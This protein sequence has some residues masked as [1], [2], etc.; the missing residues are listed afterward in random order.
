MVNV[1]PVASFDLSE[2]VFSHRP[3][4]GTLYWLPIT[5]SYITGL[6]IRVAA[7]HGNRSCHYVMERRYLFQAS[8]DFHLLCSIRAFITV[9]PQ[10]L[11][12]HTERYVRPK[13]RL[14][15]TRRSTANHRPESELRAQGQWPFYIQL[16]IPRLC[17]L[18][19]R[20]QISFSR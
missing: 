9:S 12:I 18:N 14:L 13:R 3:S 17:G 4:Q 5:A 11:L 15:Q 19:V 7:A 1:C 6:V 10:P 8:C 2:S 20:K 16:H